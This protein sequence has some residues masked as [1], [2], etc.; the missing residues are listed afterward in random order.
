[1]QNHSA[2]PAT[3]RKINYPSWDQSSHQ[4]QLLLSVSLIIV[5]LEFN[6]DSCQL[7]HYNLFKALKR[8]FLTE[9][10]LLC[11]VDDWQL[12]IWIQRKYSVIW[13]LQ[14]TQSFWS[15]TI[16]EMRHGRGKTETVSWIVLLCLLST[17]RLV[18]I[19]L[20]VKSYKGKSVTT[21]C[22]SAI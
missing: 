20:F 15:L 16:F 4:N 18:L 21:V 11:N 2:I 3:R 17:T 8:S 6:S 14:L 7:G 1:M 22:F 9:K 19:T 13:F 5:S 12:S 10:V